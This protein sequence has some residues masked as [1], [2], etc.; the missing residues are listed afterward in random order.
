MKKE[1]NENEN[2]KRINRVYIIFGIMVAI[3]LAVIIYYFQFCKQGYHSDEMWSYGYANSY[4]QKD[5]HMDKDGN[6]LY[7]GEW[8][9][10]QIL[11]DYIVVNE[12]ER[13]QYDSIYHN[14]LQDLSPP[15]HSM[16]LHTICSFFPD[17]FSRWFSFSI[18][19]VS[20]LVCMIYLFKTARLLKSDMFALCCCALY[21]FCM[22]ARD[23]YI[24]LRMYAMCTALVMII[25][26]HLLQYLNKYQENE[27]VVNG[28]LIAICLTSL[29]GFLTHYYMVSFMGILTFLV[30]V[31]LLFKKQI[32]AMFVYGFSMLIMFIASVLIFPAMIGVSQSNVEDVQQYIDYNFEIR[33]RILSN[34]IMKKIFNI[35]VPLAKTAIPR[36]IF[37][38]IVF[39]LIV[40]TPLLIFLRDTRGM[41]RFLGKL[42][43]CKKSPKRVFKYLLRRVNWFYIILTLTVICQMIVIGESSKVYGMG[44]MEDRYLFFLYPIVVIIGLALLYQVGI[45]LSR[46]RKI[47]VALLIV[48]SVV[49]VGINIYNN[50]KY[51]DYL[52]RRYGDIAIEDCLEGRDC[53]FVRN[54]PWMLTT[55]VPT[56]MS[57]D[58]FIQIE[59]EDYTDIEEHY[60]E[61]KGDKKI[62]VVIDTSFLASGVDAISAQGIE[63]EVEDDKERRQKEKLYEDMI[64]LLE[65]LEPET[66]MEHMTTQAIFGRPMIVYLINP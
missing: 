51:G 42:R 64:Q 25:L 30:C 18:N 53:I 40:I 19:I 13:F 12:D 62:A 54:S 35:T 49:W 1:N 34:F 28:N 10:T 61:H 24:Y 15:L 33:F 21:G 6:L 47:A 46:R 58:E 56:L 11:K 39:A 2:N 14:Q 41:Q 66:E 48:V 55:M 50:T 27:K 65:D 22:G 32:K 38:C 3:Q 4:Y 31:Y 17:Q 36:I 45:I 63:G 16:I 5:I 52:F 37:G 59:Y 7:V 60:K 57:A 9:D 44:A 8:L 26:Y 29:I 43:L 20:F 23:T